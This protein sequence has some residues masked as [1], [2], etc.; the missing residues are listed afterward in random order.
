MANPEKTEAQS[1]SKASRPTTKPRPWL[2]AA[3]PGMGNVAAIAAGYLVESLEMKP[4]AELSPRGHFDIQTVKVHSGVVRRP[5]LPRSL[6]Y[7]WEN[8]RANGRDLLVF[9]GEA[10]PSVGAYQFTH[11][12]LDKAQKFDVERVVTFASLA[13]QLHP[14][15]DPRVAAVATDKGTLAE[16]EKLEIRPLQD[17]EIGGLN[18]V[19]LGAAAE[20]GLTG[21]CLLGEIPFFA[22]GVPNPKGALVAL[23]AFSALSG[24]K[25]DTADLERHAKDVEEALLD[26]MERMKE[27]ARQQAQTEMGESEEFTQEES[28]E[29][30]T[31]KTPEPSPALDFATRQRIE[32]MFEEAR[33]DRSRGMRLKEELD[34]LG[35]FRLYENRFLD[36]FRKAG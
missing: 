13:S 26:L 1:E 8:P 27:E 12:L 5:R 19:L 6:F 18:G 23:R 10:Q 2:I 17:G 16:L 35:V 30:Q 36:L 34:R 31:E 22:A 21:I 28:E 14:A 4:V 3:W 9:L 20:H 7:R 15:A 24:V 25:L 32:Q 29:P 33:K 11:E